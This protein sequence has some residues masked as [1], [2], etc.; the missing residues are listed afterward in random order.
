LVESVLRDAGLQIL[1]T[2][3]EGI[4][5]RGEAAD[6]E[7]VL[8]VTPREGEGTAAAI[9]VPPVTALRGFVDLLEVVPEPA[10]F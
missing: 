8:G 2:G 6:F 3:T 9:L 10:L 4:L 5:V 7:R 1:R